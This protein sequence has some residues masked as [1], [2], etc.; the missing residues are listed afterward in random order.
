MKAS[1]V[2]LHAIFTQHCSTP[3]PARILEIV[4]NA[5]EIEKTF[6]SDSLPV[7][8]IGM[9][10]SSMKKYIEF[11]ADRLLFELGCSKHYK[12]SN[13]FEFMNMISLEGKTNFFEKKVSE[14][15]KSGVGTAMGESHAFSVD[16]DF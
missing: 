15:A 3:L 9:N 13:P 7:E 5:V 14:Y 2:N 6:I 11:C 12:T 4:S 1:T 16:A 10:S 8:L